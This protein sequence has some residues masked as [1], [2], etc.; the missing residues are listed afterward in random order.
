MPI[1]VLGVTDSC[2]QNTFVRTWG[3]SRIGQ[4]EYIFGSCKAD[5]GDSVESRAVSPQWRRNFNAE[6]FLSVSLQSRK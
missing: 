3:G 2:E 1:T 6:T 5:R 4:P